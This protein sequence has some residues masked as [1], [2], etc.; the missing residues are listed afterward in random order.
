MSEETIV[1]S[2]NVDWRTQSPGGDFEAEIKDVTD[3]SLLE[4]LGLRLYRVEPGKTAWPFHAHMAN[5]EVILLQEG[6][7]TL[8][9]GEREVSVSAGDVLCFPAD[10]DYPHQ[11]INDGDEVMQYVCVSTMFEPEAIT[12]PDSGKVGV[13]SGEPPGGESDERTFEGYFDA[14]E[15]YE[16]W[17]GELE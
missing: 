11:L 4:E 2:E 5:E 17:D 14:T 8:R 12:Y 3:H 10:P 13:L 15:R 7:G 1:D 16:Y 9:L 6:E